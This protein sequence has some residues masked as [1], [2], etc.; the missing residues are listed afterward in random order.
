MVIFSRYKALFADLTSIVPLTVFVGGLTQYRNIKPWK[1]DE[2]LS[3]EIK[4][5]FSTLGC[6]TLC[7]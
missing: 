6:K 7:T 4:N 1:V 3:G 2:F 5:F